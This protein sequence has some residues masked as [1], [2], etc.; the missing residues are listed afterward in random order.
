MRKVSA[1]SGLLGVASITLLFFVRGTIK[2]WEYQAVDDP[3]W[4]DPAQARSCMK[5]GPHQVKSLPHDTHGIDFLLED[6]D[7][8]SWGEDSQPAPYSLQNPAGLGRDVEDLEEEKIPETL[9]ARQDGARQAGRRFQQ[10]Q[11]LLS[12]HNVLRQEP[13]PFDLERSLSWQ[14][15]VADPG[16]SSISGFVDNVE[17]GP[18]RDS[19]VADGLLDQSSFTEGGVEFIRGVFGDLD[20]LEQ[21][22]TG[23]NPNILDV[24]I[25]FQHALSKIG[26]EDG[27]GDYN[28]K[29]KGSRETWL[30]HLPRRQLRK[31]GNLM[32]DHGNR[33][34]LEV[35][36]HAWV[37]EN[38]RRQ[39]RRVKKCKKVAKVSAAVVGLVVILGAVAAVVGHKVLHLW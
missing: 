33:P 26:D 36:H 21:L 13:P 34:G 22:M 19:L 29:L 11:K 3:C 23:L 30:R 32:V 18:G 24:R 28:Q 12:D 25:E 31:F 17:R 5:K 39:A 37:Q 20:D 6:D 15:G 9:V 27:L 35:W 10:R 1:V 38:E 7:D 8:F 14:R 4:H 16:S 2:S